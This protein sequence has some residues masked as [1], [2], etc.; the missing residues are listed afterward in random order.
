M[1]YELR[2]PNRFKSGFLGV[3]VKHMWY[4]SGKWVNDPIG[5]FTN[6]AGCKTVRAFRRMLRNNTHI[7]GK[8]RLIHRYVGCDVFG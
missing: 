1:R 2:R 4:Q 6:L 8:A 7:K 3:E 5:D